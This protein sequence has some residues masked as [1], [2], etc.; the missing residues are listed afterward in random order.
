MVLHIA[1]ITAVSSTSEPAKP[2]LPHLSSCPCQRVAGA[3]AV[4]A[5][6]PEGV[7]QQHAST[8]DEKGWLWWPTDCLLMEY[9]ANK[10]RGERVE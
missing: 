9:E 2:I 3:L 8:V 4:G 6:Q 5:E 10:G 1:E 7:Q